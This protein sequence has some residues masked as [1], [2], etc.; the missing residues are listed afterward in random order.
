MSEHYLEQRVFKR[1]DNETVALYR[2]LYSLETKKYAVQSLDFI[3][4]ASDFSRLLESE[5][6]FFE[7]LTEISPIEQCNW[8]MSLS[9]AIEAHDKDFA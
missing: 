7:L 4:V 2:C 9:D 6:Q 1:I 5:R 8:F 3:G